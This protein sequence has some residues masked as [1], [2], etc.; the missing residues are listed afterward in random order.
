M[1]FVYVLKSDDDNQIDELRFLAENVEANQYK[2][3]KVQKDYHLWWDKQ[4]R[5]NNYL[6]SETMKLSQ[7]EFFNEKTIEMDLAKNYY[8]HNIEDFDGEE[9][10]YLEFKNAQYLQNNLQK[11]V[12]FMDG[13]EWN[14]F[15]DYQNIDYI[16]K[17][18][19]EE[20]ELV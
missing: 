17:E 20:L 19:K 8:T 4:I 6:V 15:K 14:R 3:K 9:K 12:G 11:I 18:E 13:I 16:V 1:G 10:K 7:G 2:E 5:Y